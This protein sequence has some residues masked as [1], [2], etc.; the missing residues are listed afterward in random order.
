MTSL[1]KA[2]LWGSFISLLGTF[3]LGTLNI[4]AMQVSVSEGIMQGIFF[5]LGVAL[6]EVLYVRLSVVGISWIMKN[7]RWLRYL[8]W[9]A[10]AIVLALAF[11]SFWAAFQPTSEKNIVLTSK[12]PN[13]LLGMA[14]S[15]INPMQIPFW[16][17]WTTVMF[18]KKIL[19]NKNNYYNAYVLGIG[20]GTLLG[21]MVFVVGGAFLV[22]Y[23]HTSQQV[24]NIVIGCIFIL[25]AMILIAKILLKK[26]L[27]QSIAEKAAALET[28]EKNYP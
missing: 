20:L 26:P 12:L 25:T 23:L 18:S 6:V 17:G 19:H 14:L 24:I 9:A 5:S 8:E 3:P 11:G 22:E 10:V 1:P 21:L 2:A 27:E 28:A 7:A 15:A 4:L 16:F 13:F